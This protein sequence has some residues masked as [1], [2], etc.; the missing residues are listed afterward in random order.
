MPDADVSIADTTPDFFF[1]FFFADAIACH[2]LLAYDVF[3]T[4]AT[5]CLGCAV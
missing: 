3:A 2:H 1:F 5:D 4:N